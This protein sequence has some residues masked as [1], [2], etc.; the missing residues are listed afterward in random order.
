MHSLLHYSLTM[1]LYAL[2]GVRFR[3]ASLFAF[4][5][6]KIILQIV[7]FVCRVFNKINANVIITK[8]ATA[9]IINNATRRIKSIRF[10]LLKKRHGKL[11]TRRYY[12]ISGLKMYCYFIDTSVTINILFDWIIRIII[13]NRR[14][15]EKNKSNKLYR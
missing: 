5:M 1:C 8:H 11:K 3:A 15:I 9:R 10:T 7:C 2:L 12:L 4:M 13:I 6:I 14:R